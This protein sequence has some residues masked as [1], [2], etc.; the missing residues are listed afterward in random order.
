MTAKDEMR[1]SAGHVAARAALVPLQAE[2][3]LRA[4]LVS[5]LVLGETA[6]VQEA[7]G[8]WRRVRCDLDGYLGWVHTGY[9]VELAPD[10]AA[11]W[12]SDAAGWSL[13]AV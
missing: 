7:S 6:V 5:Q 1:V 9:L 10:A 2:R 11:A 3:S 8:E 13:G 4:E 12:R